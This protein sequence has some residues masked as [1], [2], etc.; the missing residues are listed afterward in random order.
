[1]DKSGWCGLEYYVEILFSPALYCLSL[2]K[3]NM[4]HFHKNHEVCTFQAQIV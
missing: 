2:L 3:I 1:M 4:D